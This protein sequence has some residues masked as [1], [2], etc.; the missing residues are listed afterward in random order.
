MLN[1]DDDKCSLKK[2]CKNLFLKII[3]ELALDVLYTLID[4]VYFKCLTN[5]PKMYLCTNM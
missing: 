3:K 1:S 4:I 5:H 2:M